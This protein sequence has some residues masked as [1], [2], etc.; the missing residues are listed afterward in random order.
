MAA[1]QY[2][3]ARASHGWC[4]DGGVVCGDA[5][6]LAGDRRR[7]LQR[8]DVAGSAETQNGA[9]AAGSGI[10]NA[11][12]RPPSGS[13]TPSSQSHSSAARGV[14]AGAASANASSACS[15]APGWLVTER[16]SGSRPQP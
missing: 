13:E 12:G 14:V 1:R 4:G 15:A 3:V 8:G 9:Q 7:D 2:A 5:V 11:N 10:G 16:R 6:R